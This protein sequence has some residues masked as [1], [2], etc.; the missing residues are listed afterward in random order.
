MEDTKPNLFMFM[1]ESFRGD[2]VVRWWFY[3]DLLV[4][5]PSH[6]SIAIMAPT[7]PFSRYGN[8]G[9]G[10]ETKVRLGK[11]KLDLHGDGICVEKKDDKLSGLQVREP[12]SSHIIPPEL[13]IFRASTQNFPKGTRRGRKVW[14]QKRG[15]LG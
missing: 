7:L 8:E 2:F 4:M 3:G 1:Q 15:S 6:S 10:P 14:T 13:I 11:E 5:A 9:F 12:P